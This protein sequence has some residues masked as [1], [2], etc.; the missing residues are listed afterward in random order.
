MT[1]LRLPAGTPSA[2]QRRTEAFCYETS[3]SKSAPCRAGDDAD[4]VRRIRSDI[5][6]CSCGRVRCGKRRPDRLTLSTSDDRH[7]PDGRKLDCSAFAYFMLST[8]LGAPSV[9]L[10]VSWLFW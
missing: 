5:C 4:L 7:L 3:A 10:P 2:R 9:T 1:R 6:F 8:A